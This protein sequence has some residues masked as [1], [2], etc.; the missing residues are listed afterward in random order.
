MTESDRNS[1]PGLGVVVIAS[2]CG[3]LASA[4]AAAAILVLLSVVCE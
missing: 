1:V 2:I 4:A 3:M